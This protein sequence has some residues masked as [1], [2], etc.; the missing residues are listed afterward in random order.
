MSPAVGSLDIVLQHGQPYAA[1]LPGELRLC[2]VCLPYR[3]S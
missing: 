3:D 2:A 1:F